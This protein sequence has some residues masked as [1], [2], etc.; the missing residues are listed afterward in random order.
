MSVH[1][2]RLIVGGSLAGSDSPYGFVGKHELREFGGRQAEESVLYLRLYDVEIRAVFTLL[3]HFADA[4]YR[5][6]IVVER[7]SHLFLEGFGGFTI[8]LAT[9]RVAENHVGSSGRG[10][11]RRAH[12]T[13]VSSAL[14][15]GAVFCTESE[16]GV[17]H[18]IDRSQMG[19]RHTD[20]YIA[21]HFGV[22]E[23][24]V[25]IF[26]QAYTFLQGGVHFPVACYDFLSHYLFFN[27]IGFLTA[28]ILSFP[29][30]KL[31]IKI[32]PSTHLGE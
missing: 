23:S 13:G 6:E 25:D 15:V 19:E 30:A 2:L 3:E 20:H 9:L 7:K 32:K 10:Y 27:N 11:H 26:C 28:E 16:L 8:I 24:F 29:L 12:L 17:D 14:V 21:L 4:E 31:A 18:F 5:S 1:L 22:L